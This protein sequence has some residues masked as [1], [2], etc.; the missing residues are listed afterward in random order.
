M[1]INEEALQQ[2]FEDFYTRG[3]QDSL[4]CYAVWDHGVETVGAGLRTLKEAQAN[5]RQ[6]PFFSIPEWELKPRSAEGDANG[7]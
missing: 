7:S 1:D 5:C 2:M 6:D 4:K 3:Y